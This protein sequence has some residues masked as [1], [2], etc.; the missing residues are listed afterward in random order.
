M[1][2]ETRLKCNMKLVDKDGTMDWT[3]NRERRR[4]ILAQPLTN[5]IVPNIN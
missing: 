3:L 1:V 4:S 2:M 5:G